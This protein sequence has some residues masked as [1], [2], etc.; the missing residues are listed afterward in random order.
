M[1]TWWVSRSSSAPVSRLDPSTEVQSSNGHVRR[2][3][4][5][6]AFVALREGLEQQLGASQGQGN[7]AEFVDDQQL[8]GC[9]VALK[10]EQPSFI[11]DFEQLADQRGGDGERHR[12]PLLASCQA[13]REGDVGLAAVAKVLSV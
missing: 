13:E 4:G 9:Q 1:L 6:A 11:A 2:D 3:D 5:R 12:K 7:A 10:L 8:C